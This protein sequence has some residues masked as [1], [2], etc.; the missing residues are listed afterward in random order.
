[1]LLMMVLLLHFALNAF[2]QQQKKT[3]VLRG[4][5]TGVPEQA[6]AKAKNICYKLTVFMFILK[7]QKTLAL[8]KYV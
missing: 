3:L 2:Q 4:R 7:H 5:G 6:F 8:V 1:M